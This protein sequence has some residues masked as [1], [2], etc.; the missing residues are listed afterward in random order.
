M[1]T[2]PTRRSPDFRETDGDTTTIS[3]RTLDAAEA[4]IRAADELL[5][6]TAFSGWHYIVVLKEAVDALR[7]ELGED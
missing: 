1:I 5:Y 3:T 7:A 2:S 4:V 6:D